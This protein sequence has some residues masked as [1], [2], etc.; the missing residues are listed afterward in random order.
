MTPRAVETAIIAAALVIACGGSGASGSGGNAGMAGAG[1]S[2]SGGSAGTSASGGSA[3]TS[4]SGGSAGTSGSGGSAGMSGSGGSAGTS[5]SGGSAGTS[6]SGGSAGTSASGGSAGASGSA[7][8]A[9]AGGATSVWYDGVNLSGAEFGESHLPGN[10]GSDYTYPTNA[11]IDYF[12]AKGMTILRVPF[13]WE[14]LQQTT[15]AALDAT[16][17]G[18]LDAVVTHA[19][20]KGAHVLLDP[21]NYARYYGDVVGG[22]TVSDADFAD[23]W[24]RLAAHYKTND[25][26]VFGLM[27]E[28]HDLPTEQWLASAN[29]AIVAIRAAGASQLVLVPGNA[30]TGAHSWSASW[31][32]T[33]NS[34]AMTAVVD[35]GNN[36]A[37]ELHE[38]LDADF[39]G[40]SASCQSAT[41]GSQVLAPVTAW[42][43]EQRLPRLPRRACRWRQRDVRG[44]GHRHAGTRA[45]ERGRVDRL[46]VVGR[47]TLVGQL[48][49]HARA[50]E[51]GLEPGGRA[52]AELAHAVPVASGS[53]RQRC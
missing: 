13:R 7:G 51:P 27:N 12:V 2:G 9:G 8:A 47:R 14:R 44:G 15:G 42:L 36:F 23:F 43:R 30:W 35:S 46:V 21:H 26:V 4:A 25:R 3:G 11:E 38:Y 45:A 16:E 18:R 37:F 17:L 32:G 20:Q 31:Y 41:I 6:A 50:Q 22:G 5:A 53:R 34:Q 49:V 33:P 28:P 29:A 19:T 24:S 52:P 48:H 10:Y 39:S 1:T 40:T